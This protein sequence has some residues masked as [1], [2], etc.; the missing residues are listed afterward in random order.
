MKTPA[1]C[2]VSPMAERGAQLRLF[3]ACELP[4]DVRGELADLQDVL[5]GLHGGRLRWVRPHGIHITLKFLGDVEE[6]RVQA[7]TSALVDAIEP[8][9]IR[10]H[11]AA[12]G[13]FGGARLRVLWIG[14]EGDTE[15]L[16]DL[17]RRI[18]RALGMIGFPPERRPFAAHLTLARVPEGA[19][20]AER[21]ELAGLIERHRM[22][23]L[24]PIFLTEVR[25]IRSV[26]RPGGSTY[27]RLATFPEAKT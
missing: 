11:L 23:P 20:A 27:H 3:I 6:T 12:L 17:A 7:I 13:G 15:P 19:S 10:L 9:E 25:L 16:A 21:Q 26:L 18:D 14:L 5:R 4:D 22:P 8:F 1:A 2:S 24:R